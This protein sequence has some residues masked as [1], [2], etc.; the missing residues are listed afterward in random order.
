ML[1]LWIIFGSSQV[2]KNLAYNFQKHYK[3]NRKS[4]ATYKVSTVNLKADFNAGVAS[5]DPTTT[6]II[7]WSRAENY[8]GKVVVYVSESKDFKRSYTYTTTTSAEV[9]FIIKI[10]AVNLTPNT[11]YYY[12]FV[13]KNSESIIGR[14]KTLPIDTSTMKL[15][16]A[17]CANYQYGFF[18]SYKVMAQLNVDIVIFLGDYIYEYANKQYGGDGTSKNRI[19]KPD[20][21]LLSL[22]DYRQRHLQYKQDENLSYLHQRVPF[23]AVWDDH[24]F[25]NNAWREGS[26][27]YT[28]LF[29]NRKLAAAQAYFEYM[30]IRVFP[31]ELL[32]PIYRTFKVGNLFELI[33]LDTRLYRD[34][35]GIRD[36][37]RVLDPNRSILGK[38]QEAWLNNLPIQYTR[39]SLYG[40]QILFSVLISSLHSRGVPI[41]ADSW[42]GYPASR[43]RMIDFMTDRKIKSK[44]QP[45]LLTG[46]IHISLY[47]KFNN[48]TEIV[49]PAVASPNLE[50]PKFNS[51]LS[52]IA[53]SF[54]S[55]DYA[56]LHN[57]GFVTLDVFSSHLDV[58]WIYM[59]SKTQTQSLEYT[60]GNQIRL[61]HD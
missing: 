42:D 26:Q 4:P 27:N 30:P 29:P 57:K 46:D 50:F 40:N 44:S 33:M 21:V 59:A 5:G 13:A 8:D 14:T 17:S 15:A 7:L 25:A 51:F 39:W 2:I 16:V 48:L 45:V 23:I 19:P 31:K 3:S 28:D 38:D 54:K 10:D 12:K 34:V 43:Q 20:K 41:L 32:K 9:D 47:N 24:E 61:N 55:I 60:I 18:T 11:V 37:K 52:A 56:D 1:L 53:Q 35:T 49:T 36:R 58:K 22:Q 6:S